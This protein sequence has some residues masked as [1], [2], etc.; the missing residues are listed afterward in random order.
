M[1]RSRIN[2]IV[3]PVAKKRRGRPATGLGSLVGTRWSEAD[4]EAIDVWRQGQEDQPNRAEA[5]R[6]LVRKGLGVKPKGRK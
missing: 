4:V 1:S 3:K 5:I 6:Q 2:D